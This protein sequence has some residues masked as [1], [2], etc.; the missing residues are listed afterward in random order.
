MKRIT[1]ILVLTVLIA[2]SATDSVQAGEAEPADDKP[3][4]ELPAKVAILKFDDLGYNK[5][6]FPLDGIHPLFKKII[7]YCVERGIKS[8]H[9]IVGKTVE[10]AP[11]EYCE[12]IKNLH[13]SGMVEFWCHG[14]RGRATVD[15]VLEPAEFE[16]DY[17]LQLDSLKKSQDV[18][19]RKFGFVYKTFGPHY[20][21]QNADT[22]KALKEVP[23][24]KLV[25]YWPDDLAKAANVMSLPRTGLESPTG[26][27]NFEAF[28]K[29]FD[30]R[31]GAS[32]VVIQGHPWGFY[33][34]GWDDLVKVIDFLVEDGWTFM[35]PSEYYNALTNEAVDTKE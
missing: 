14:Y 34:E 25:F 11:L 26:R 3:P 6:M 15:G 16:V 9:G 1:L 31:K 28:K 20:S 35:T 33:N 18:A 27:P 5:E 24:I 23:D 17:D 13:K 8:S 2:T 32:P 21:G 22:A 4:T 19:M 10:D 7:D 29:S 12:W 30:Q